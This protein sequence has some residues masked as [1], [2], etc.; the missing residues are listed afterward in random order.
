[1]KESDTGKRFFLVC[2]SMTSKKTDI[3]N[4]YSLYVR[5]LLFKLIKESTTSTDVIHQQ[6]MQMLR[7]PPNRRVRKSVTAVATTTTT[8]EQNQELRKLFDEQT[9]QNRAMIDGLKA[10]IANMERAQSVENTIESEKRQLQVQLEASRATEAELRNQMNQQR[11]SHANQVADLEQ[12][13]KEAEQKMTRM[14]GDNGKLQIKN[15]QLKRSL[16]RREHDLQYIF[17]KLRDELPTNTTTHKDGVEIKPTTAKEA[18][19]AHTSLLRETLDQNQ[20]LSTHHRHLH[21]LTNHMAEWKMAT[22]KRLAAKF[23]E[24]LSRVLGD[25]RFFKAPQNLIVY[26]LF[27]GIYIWI[28]SL[29]FQMTFLI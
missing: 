13:L 24:E 28:C 17:E 18:L 12:R 23:E 25:R 19:L 22:A 21:K 4:I 26:E 16:L 6:L 8:E 9:E 14:R 2:S 1:M 20:R 29:T 10:K 11:V 15:N 3:I 5:S 7:P 27:V